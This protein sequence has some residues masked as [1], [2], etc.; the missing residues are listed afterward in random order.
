MSAS[1]P[2]PMQLS[3]PLRI[4]CMFNATVWLIA[5]PIKAE[6][7]AWSAFGSLLG[8]AFWA[9][10]AAWGNRAGWPRRATLAMALACAAYLATRI[11]L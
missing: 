5:H 4:I 8:A 1:A 6:S 2:D 7:D 10:L 11:R 9:A 3:R